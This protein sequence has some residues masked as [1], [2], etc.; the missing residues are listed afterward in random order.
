M[1][2]LVVLTL[3]GCAS[4]FLAIM[5]WAA[6]GDGEATFHS[7]KCQL[8]HKPDRRSAGPSLAEIAKAYS[9]QEQGLTSYLKGES[10]PL[11]DLGKGKVMERQLEKTKELSDGQR[12]DLAEYILSFGGK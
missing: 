1:K 10:E 4:L 3:I 11:V 2:R 5:L 12:R 8:C 6:A 9:G 7:M